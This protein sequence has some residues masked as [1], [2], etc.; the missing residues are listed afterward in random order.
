MIL[1]IDNYDS[2]TYNLYQSLAAA[3][4]QVEVVRN[5]A[6]TIVEALAP[7][8]A[9]VVISPG[10]GNPDSAGICLELVRSLPA[11]TPLLGVCL[12]HQT[13]VQALG[14]T[15]DRSAVPVHGKPAMVHH[16]GSCPLFAGLP[17]P[18]SA[19]RY[20]SLYARRE[21]LPECLRLTAWV[22]DGTVM[23][24]RHVKRPWVGLQFH[25][26]SILTPQGDRMLRRFLAATGEGVSAR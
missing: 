9:G 22:E 14:G 6:I 5:D 8:P 23:A 25:P 1:L 21:E 12:G 13:L 11:E 2:F 3:G 18:F 24:V 16:D 17:N 7:A 19:G 15:I 4:A 10:P 20:H 26:E